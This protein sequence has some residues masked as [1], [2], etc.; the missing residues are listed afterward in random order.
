MNRAA[1]V[2][3]LA[4][5]S[6]FGCAR[7]ET[8]S[9]G[10]PIDTTRSAA[11]EVRASV[12]TTHRDLDAGSV[13]DLPIQVT[14]AS[15]AT[16]AI[17]SFRGHA[18]LVTMFYA[19][20][21]NACPLLTTDLKRI[22]ARLSDAARRDVRVLMVSFDQARDTPAVLTRL[23][24][25]RRMDATRW[26]LAS[27]RDDEARQLAGVLGIRYR[28]LDNG[29]FFHSSAIVLLDTH[30]RP[31]ARVDGIGRDPAA[32]VTALEETVGAGRNESRPNRI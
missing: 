16:K 17:D 26:T 3:G 12:S 5:W 32:M 8:A 4:I 11:A 1:L 13:Y 23:M 28:R 24:S 10:P 9:T 20:C 2:A 7:Q 19:G 31:V 15:G 27:A 6:A 14:D 18:L 29:E 22:D 21:A 30:G 25:D